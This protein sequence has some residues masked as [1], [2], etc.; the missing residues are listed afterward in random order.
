MMLALQPL[1]LLELSVNVELVASHGASVHRLAN[2]YTKP[3]V[4]LRQDRCNH[5]DG[6]RG[7]STPEKELERKRF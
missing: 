6:G 1:R 5:G 2:T 4:L 7:V 3:R